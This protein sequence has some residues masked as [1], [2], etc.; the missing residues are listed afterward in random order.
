[1][2]LVRTPG[3]LR[4]VGAACTHYGAALAGGLVVG[5]TLRCPW[6]HASFDL[7]S[8]EAIGG[9]A[10]NPLPCWDV[11]EADG[12]ITVGRPRAH[13]APPPRAG[14][15]A[16]DSVVIVGAGAAGESAAEELR[17]RGY[18]GPVTLVD[19]D[20][21][22]P[23]D[24]PNLSKDSLSGAAPEDWLWLH[25]DD[26]YVSRRLTRYQGRVTSLDTRA[27]RVLLESG[28]SVGYGALL[29]ATGAT[30]LQPEL[31]GAGPRVHTLRS[32]KDLRAVLKAAEGKR[33]AVV[34][35]ASFIGLEVA[36][37]LCARG[38][39]VH[40]VAPDA[41]PL[42]RVLGPELGAVV[43]TLHEAK[44]VVFHLGRRPAGLVSGGVTLGDG[45]TVEGDVIVAGVGVR[46]NLELAE[47]AGLAVDRGVLVDSF[48]R[49]SDPHI[50]AAGDAARY[51]DHRLG[52]RV[53]IEHWSVA[54]NQGRVA[55][56]NLLGLE[57]PFLD[58][59]FFWSQHYDV[60]IGY[61]GHAEQWDRVEVEGDPAKLDCT[62]RYLLDGRVL[63]VAT[64]GRDRA[65]LEAHAAMES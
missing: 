12:R 33:R 4:A 39:E 20:P 60:T 59:P 54:Q 30:P 38:L 46:P 52:A 29:L 32:V 34:L 44:G 56:R 1:V 61:V 36:A 8:G 2:L 17:R 11:R 25:P 48:L 28:E 31:T 43:R 55:A 49:T 51:P 45:S 35:G 64:I 10:L 27:R 57:T 62:V 53:R 16:P 14:A 47:L 13:Q 9:P 18:E 15:G 63:A 3:G 41:T 21:E 6:H 50:W 23:I 42:V 58:V 19:A 22:T 24:R 26:F 65:S 7:G 40:V 5:E 37:S